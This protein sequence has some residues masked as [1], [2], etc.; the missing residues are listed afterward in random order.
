MYSR[1]SFTFA[2]LM[3]ASSCSVS[4]LVDYIDE[5]GHFDRSVVGA[6]DVEANALTGR[7]LKP[8]VLRLAASP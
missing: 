4:E 7:N 1:N 8:G 6:L 2:N 5:H 3:L